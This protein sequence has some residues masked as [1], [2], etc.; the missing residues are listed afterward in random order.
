M[1]KGRTGEFL[2]R[3]GV[4]SHEDTD[5]DTASHPSMPLVN[6]WNSSGNASLLSEDVALLD[7]HP[8]GM[9]LHKVLSVIDT[10]R[11]WQSKEGHCW[12]WRLMAVVTPHVKR[13]SHTKRSTAAG[14][15]SP[16]V[17]TSSQRFWTTSYTKK[18]KLRKVR[19]F[20]R[21]ARGT[22]GG[23]GVRAGPSRKPSGGWTDA[24][25]TALGSWGR[26]LDHGY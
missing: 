18:P 5:E 16:H 20:T 6:A 11:A 8:S 2:K 3:N 22:N 4:G 12:R 7:F 9:E 21:G 10:A 24:A 14:S 1:P 17:D 23:L 19:L 15:L 13:L 26:S 25:S